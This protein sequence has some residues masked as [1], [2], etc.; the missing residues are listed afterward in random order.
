MLEDTQTPLVAKRNRQHDPH[1][2][3]RTDAEWKR[4]FRQVPGFRLVRDGY[5]GAPVRREGIVFGV[6][7]DE[8][9]CFSKWYVLEARRERQL[10]PVDTLPPTERATL[11]NGTCVPYRQ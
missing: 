4:L 9:R 5:V 10:H 11:V 7:G 3:F 2:T 1:G 8:N 6:R